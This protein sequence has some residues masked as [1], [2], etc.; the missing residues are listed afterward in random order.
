MRD[1]A[2]VPLVDIASAYT[3]TGNAG[4]NKLIINTKQL[5]VLFIFRFFNDKPLSCFLDIL[6]LKF[7]GFFIF[8][9]S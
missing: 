4:S 2:A 7:T 6:P 3:G 5:T 8:H 1:I 9:F